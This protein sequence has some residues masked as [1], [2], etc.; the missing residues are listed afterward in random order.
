MAMEELARN[1]LRTFLSLF[2]VTIGIFC[3][4]SILATVNSLEINIRSEIH[5]LGTNTIYVDKWEYSGGPDYPFWKYAKR[6]VPN[7]D[8][9][10]E[11]KQR[12][13]TAKYVAFKINLVD[14]VEWLDHVAR[15][16]RLYGISQDFTN[17][18][19]LDIQYGRF[20]SEAEFGRGTNAIVIGNT[21]A[22]NLFGDAAQA[23]NQMVTIRG[24]KNLVAGVIKKQGTQ[25]IG[26]WGFDESVLMPYEYARTI[27]DETKADPLVMVQ[28][29]D[30]VSSKLLKDDL[31]AVMRSVH[32]LRPTEADDF[33]LND[34]ND[35]SLVLS[36]VF[37][38]INMGGWAIGALAFIVGIFGVANIMFVTVK[39]RT[40]QIGIKKALGAKSSFILSEFLMESAFLCILGGLIG[41]LM[42]YILLKIGSVVSSFPIFIPLP[43]IGL[44]IL[45]SI[46]AGIAAGI[47]PAVQAAR[48][49][50]VVAIRV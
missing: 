30:G 13:P 14:K 45:I 35:F 25:L 46:A 50:P 32:K 33:S 17:I 26:G 39:E 21:L 3:I 37:S 11:I 36:K 40:A 4:I 29:K 27:M 20:L 43:I 28:G 22:E 38:S 2:G 34:I 8:E 24:K 5:S 9:V 19:P 31:T 18:Q 47:I 15:N 12:T 41:L 42:V 48:M 23:V 16:T 10:R 44:S 7:Y 1:R 6:P 49:N